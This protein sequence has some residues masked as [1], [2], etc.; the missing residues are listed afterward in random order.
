MPRALTLT[1]SLQTVLDFIV[2]YKIDHD[3]VSPSVLEIGAG[4]DISSTSMVRYSLDCLE[5]LGLIRCGYGEKS[6]S[7]MISVT[8][9]R[10]VPPRSH[11]APASK[12]ADL[13]KS[14]SSIKE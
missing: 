10:W 12:R 14:V 7:R 11:Q 1:P 6:R 5:R 8:G 3:G 4:C 9:G 13:L 2:K